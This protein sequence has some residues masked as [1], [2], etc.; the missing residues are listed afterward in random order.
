[1]KALADYSPAEAL[2]ELQDNLDTSTDHGKRVDQLAGQLYLLAIN[3]QS[4]A[5]DLQLH[6]KQREH[7]HWNRWAAITAL[8]AAT[9]GRKT[10]ERARLADIHARYL[11]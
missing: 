1:M 3:A 7:Q 9:D 4:R 10:I 6:I 5:A 11:R 8:L 2:G